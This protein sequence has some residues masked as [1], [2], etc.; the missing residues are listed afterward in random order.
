[1]SL[2]KKP[3][4]WWIELG[5]EVRAE[6]LSKID[7]FYPPESDGSA[8]PA[9]SDMLGWYRKWVVELYKDPF[10]LLGPPPVATVH[11]QLARFPADETLPVSAIANVN[12]AVR[13]ITV[14][15]VYI[16]PPK[17]KKR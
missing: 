11:P 12:R 16:R 17:E 3:E 15:K 9:R 5:D 1:M 6:A 2:E 14:L 8:G 7:E 10:G 4:A 13:T